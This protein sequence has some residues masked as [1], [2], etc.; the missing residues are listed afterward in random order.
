M[1]FTKAMKNMQKVLLESG[2]DIIRYEYQKNEYN[3]SILYTQISGMNNQITLFVRG[4][5]NTVVFPIFFKNNGTTYTTEKYIPNECFRAILDYIKYYT[6]VVKNETKIS[7]TLF[8]EEIRTKMECLN[9]SEI[10]P[11]NV[12]QLR[13]N[14]INA[15][16]I[17]NPNDLPFFYTLVHSK[18]SNEM[19]DKIRRIYNN[20]NKIINFLT[21]IGYTLRFTDDPLLARDL[22][23]ELS[24]M[25]FKS[26]K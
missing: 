3:I 15:H 26:E 13:E 14:I 25:G 11:Q 7:T 16:R 4:E 2:Y 6:V 22:V 9:L 1:D 8:F 20:S 23:L 5:N 12:R 21:H 24:E 19:K 17:R 18:M 10:I